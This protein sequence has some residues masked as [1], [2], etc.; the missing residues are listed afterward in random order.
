MA[1][2]TCPQC[3]TVSEFDDGEQ[4]FCPNCDYPLF[5]AGRTGAEGDD[6]QKNG[7]E[8]GEI[9][10]DALATDVICR[11]CAE[12]N[13]G[14][15]TFCQRCGAEL[16]QAPVETFDPEAPPLMAEFP[17]KRDRSARILAALAGLAM[18]VAVFGGGYYGYIRVRESAPVVV[19]AL[20]VNG[21]TGF[22]TAIGFGE[23]GP[24]IAYRGADKVLH[25]LRCKNHECTDRTHV[26]LVSQGDPGYDTAIDLVGPPLILYRDQASKAMRAVRCGTFACDNG[27]GTRRFNLIDGEDAGFGPSIAVGG[28]IAIT[29]Y[30]TNGGALR[31]AFLCTSTCAESDGTIIDKGSDNARVITTIDQGSGVPGKPGRQAAIAIP[32][33]GTPYV[34]FREEDTLSLRMVRCQN[35]SCSQLD[36]PIVLATGD[37]GYDPA[38]IIGREGFPIV[39][40]RD[41]EKSTVVLVACGDPTC[42]EDKRVT[43]V[44][45]NGG[46]LAHKVGFSLNMTPGKEGNP[47]LAYRDDTAGSLRV[48]I[49][50]DAGCTGPQRTFRTVDG[51]G[52]GSKVG[53]ELSAKQSGGF[54]YLAYR[55]EA[56]KSLKFARV[57]L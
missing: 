51:G 18:L 41:G 44:V 22:S 48:V 52:E 57:R 35:R 14:T 20:D 55:D 16:V 1:D 32:L 19:H 34:A 6:A 17:P 2:V 50:G 8:R 21:D 9:E 42:T 53:H 28:G 40:Y 10:L 36:A 23:D 30:R 38:M 15:R 12:R 49:C 24:V 46:E 7:V 43:T 39:A 33:G 4:G 56:A 3:G 45:D 47:V 5:W 25:Y 13:P 31:T 26:S 11:A 27:E 29:A 54:L 37:V